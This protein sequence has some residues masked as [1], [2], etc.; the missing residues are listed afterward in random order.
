M[1]LYNWNRYY[2]P[3]TGRYLSADS[4][5]IE[6]GLNPFTYVDNN[7]LRWFD[8]TD[9]AKIGGGKI[10][11]FPIP[12]PPAVPGAPSAPGAGDVPGLMSRVQGLVAERARASGRSGAPQINL[13]SLLANTLWR[14]SNRVMFAM[15]QQDQVLRRSAATINALMEESSRKCGTCEKGMAVVQRNYIYKDRYEELYVYRPRKKENR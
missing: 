15:T 14:E 4:L 9:Q 1:A 6:A 13:V 3:K 7:P 2:D 5:G 11:P 10:I 12:A 8:P